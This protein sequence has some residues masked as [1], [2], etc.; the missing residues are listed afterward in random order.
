MNHASPESIVEK[1][2]KRYQVLLK[3]YDLVDDDVRQTVRPALFYETGR[4]TQ[5]EIFRVL[6]YLTGEGVGSERKV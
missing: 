1:Q 3:I 4:T 5:D 6:D 2:K